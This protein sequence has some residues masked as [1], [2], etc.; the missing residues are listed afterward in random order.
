[1]KILF[2]SVIVILVALIAAD[3]QGWLGIRKEAELD[4]FNVIFATKDEDSGELIEDFFVNCTRRGSRNACSIEQGMDKMQRK[5][6][7]GYLRQIEKTRLFKKGE[8]IIGEDDVVVH[9]MFI[10]QDY[11]RRTVSYSMQELL[12]LKDQLVTVTLN[13]SQE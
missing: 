8:S 6:K 10:H 1:M 5:V 3:Y 9:L 4:Y 12:A 7:F 13:R 11:A 2:A